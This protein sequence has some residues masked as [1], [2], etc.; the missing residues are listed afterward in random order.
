MLELIY[1]R[2][3]QFGAPR[4]PGKEAGMERRQSHRLY[5]CLPIEWRAALRD[6]A[7]TFAAKAMMKNI[8]QGGVYLECDTQPHLSKGVVGHFTFRASARQQES[9]AI[10]LAAKARVRRIDHHHDGRFPFGLAVEFLSG[11]LIFY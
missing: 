9:G 7:S 1:N 11:P 2:M 6:Q 8:S 4:P 10:H 5:T 3:S